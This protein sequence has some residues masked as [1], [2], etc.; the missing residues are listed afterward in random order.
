MRRSYLLKGG[1]SKGE[2]KER[3]VGVSFCYLGQDMHAK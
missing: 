1:R 2:E 3:G